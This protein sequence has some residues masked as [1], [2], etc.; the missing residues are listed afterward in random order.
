MYVCVFFFP[1]TLAG[2]VKK[3][4][5]RIKGDATLTYSNIILCHYHCYLRL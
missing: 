1:F 2:Y 5:S 3:G 4:W